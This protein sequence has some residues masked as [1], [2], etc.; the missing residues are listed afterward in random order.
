MNALPTLVALVALFVN[1]PSV[2]GDAADNPGSARVVASS[3]TDSIAPPPTESTLPTRNPTTVALPS[4]ATITVSFSNPE[5]PRVHETVAIEL[6]ENVADGAQVHASLWNLSLPIPLNAFR[7]AAEVGTLRLVSDA[8]ASH[9]RMKALREAADESH[10][11]VFRGTNHNKFVLVDKLAT[12]EEWVVYTTSANFTKHQRKWEQ[13]TVVHVG[14]KLLYDSYLDYWESLR[15]GKPVA[16]K[17]RHGRVK[18]WTYPTDSGH[19][20]FEGIAA[21]RCDESAEIT[22]SSL[23]FRNTEMAR[24]LRR[25]SQEGCIVSVRTSEH[26][27]DANDIWILTNGTDVTLTYANTHTKWMAIDKAGRRSNAYVYTGSANINERT[28]EAAD[29]TLRLKGRTIYDAFRSE[30]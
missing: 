3:T 21:A 9:W 18:L 19:A 5:S 27:A 16:L 22:I 29:S 15:V 14:N 17:R 11:E 8:S 20:F 25:A 2:P 13:T 10:V 23:Q 4:G 24:A 12:G 28:H 7:H 1:A 30:G 6:L 26:W